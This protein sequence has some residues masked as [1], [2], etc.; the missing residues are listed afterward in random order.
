MDIRLTEPMDPIYITLE[1]DDCTILFIIAT[2]PVRGEDPTR[3]RNPNPRRIVSQASSRATNPV[4]SGVPAAR[5]RPFEEGAEEGHARVG[6]RD[7]VSDG[8]YAPRSR[9]GDDRGEFEPAHGPFVVC[10]VQGEHAGAHQEHRRA[11][12]QSQGS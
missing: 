9:A 6:A 10:G 2:N 4:A 8:R 12:V 5:K 7:G 1:T 3:V 11:V